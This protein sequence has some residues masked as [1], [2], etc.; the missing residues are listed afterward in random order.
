MIKKLFAG[1]GVV[2][3]LIL[4][5]AA[6]KPGDFSV[7]RSIAIQAPPEKI[8]PL[9]NDF[10]QWPSWSPWEKLDPD[11]KRTLSGP[12]SGPGSIYE[13]EGNSK[14]GKGRMEITD[15]APSSKVGVKLDFTKP[16]ESSNVVAFTLQPNGSST[17]V[18]WTM[19]GP[20]TYPG[21][22]ISVFMSMDKLIGNDFETGLANMK[23][24]AEK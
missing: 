14:A 9:I 10:H 1:I 20:L 16:M 6:F 7:Q 18:T 11:M 8:F 3:A 23:A 13:W 12:P 5:Y 24:A 21:K 15:S 19:S 2:V 22:V 4:I 17:T